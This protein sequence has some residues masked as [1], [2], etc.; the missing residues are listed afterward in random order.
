MRQGVRA[1]AIG[2][3]LGAALAFAA[4]RLIGA[5]LFGVAPTDLVAFGGA[6]ALLVGAALVASW[7]PARRAATVDPLLALRA[8]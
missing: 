3:S 2:V 7:I 5:F 1:A 8:E 6:G 4:T